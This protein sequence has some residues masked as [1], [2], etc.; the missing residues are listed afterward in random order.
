[1]QKETETVETQLTI[2]GNFSFFNL[3]KIIEVE[4]YLIFQILYNLKNT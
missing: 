4:N 3:K 1:M 2:S